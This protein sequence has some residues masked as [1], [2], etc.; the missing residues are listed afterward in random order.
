MIK[1]INRIRNYNLFYFALIAFAISLPFSEALVSISSGL[2]FFIALTEDTLENK[3]K[4]FNKNRFLLLISAV[5][6]IYIIS[7]VFSNRL[8][9]S[10]Y[11]LRKSLFFLIIP[12]AFIFGKEL[13]GKQKRYLFYFFLGAV[14]ISTFIALFRYLV[15]NR[16]ADIDIRNISLISH[17]RFSF[18]LVMA[19]WFCIVLLTKNHNKLNVYGITA[20]VALSVYLISFLLFQHSLTGLII[21]ISTLLFFVFYLICQTRGIKRNILLFFSILLIVIPLSYVLWVIY[22]FYGIEEIEKQSIEHK[23]SMGNMYSHDF[24]NPIVENGH[25][26]YLY[27]C[28]K[29]LREEWNKISEFK[30]DSTG[31]NGFPVHS[32]LIRYLT[33]KGLRK[34]AAGVRS[35]NQGDIQ[36]IEKGIANVI[37]QNKKFSLYP[38]IYQ[39]VWEFYVYSHTGYANNQSLSQRIEFA[40]AACNIIRKNFLFGVGTGNWMEEFKNAYI[41]NNSK[42]DERYYASSHNQY[43]NYMVKFGFI[44]FSIIVFLLT[45]PILKTKRYHDI[46]FMLFLVFMFI[47]N[48]ADS[49]FES[50]MGSSFFV[51]FFCFF[52]VT[53]GTKYMEMSE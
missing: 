29:E 47:A 16:D 22:D 15:I 50:H 25:F 9:A 35:L 13:S 38:R 26:V 52:L 20:L 36:N 42:L 32:T 24:D 1:S 48:F 14:T 51:F 31:Q 40:R 46:Y 27:V 17:I 28:E 18:Q 8:S 6:L 34:D 2:L 44:G 37:Y 53:N 21:L 33:S 39:T 7:A 10:L 12:I 45:W 23:T 11:D 19:L 5:Y 3:L 30:Y 49:N 43:L 4:R 41:A